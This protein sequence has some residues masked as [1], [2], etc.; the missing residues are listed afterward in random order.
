MRA[1][2]ENSYATSLEFFR[3]HIFSPFFYCLHGA[4]SQ[5]V[6]PRNK[7]YVSTELIHS[8]RVQFGWSRQPH[9]DVASIEPR[10]MVAWTQVSCRQTEETNRTNEIKKN[11]HKSYRHTYM[12]NCAS[13][14]RTQTILYMP[15][16]FSYETIPSSQSK[17]S[18]VFILIETHSTTKCEDKTQ[19]RNSNNNKNSSKL[20]IIASTKRKIITHLYSVQCHSCIQSIFQR[21]FKH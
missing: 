20:E 16:T 1:A 11:T 5:S 14:Q 7:S 19:H 10:T 13:E 12:D 8:C 2:R 15:M 3:L 21:V 17:L 9:L 18:A 4:V 6:C